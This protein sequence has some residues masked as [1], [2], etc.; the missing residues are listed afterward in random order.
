MKKIVVLVFTAILFASHFFLLSATEFDRNKEEKPCLSSFTMEEKLAF[1]SSYGIEVP[2]Y[3]EDYIVRLIDMVETDPGRQIVINNPVVYQT[4][5]Q[6]KQIVNEY[7]GIP[8]DHELQQS[9]RYTLVDSTVYGSWYSGL[10]NYNC[11]AYAIGDSTA[12]YWPG[13]FSVVPNEY[14]LN[15]SN[16]IYTFATY[17]RSD[18]KSSDFSKQCVKLTTVRPSSLS[19][20]QSCMAIRK[21][22][23]DFHFMKYDPSYWY[24]K[25]GGSSILKY[26]YQPTVGRTWTNEYS[27][28]GVAH[29][30]DTYYNSDIYY[31]VYRSNHPSTTYRW[32]GEHYHS[33]NKHYF[34]YGDQ[35][36]EC[37]EFMNLEWISQSCSGPPCQ[38]PGN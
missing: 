4:A 5:T 20:G 28:D 14:N 38:M 13:A 21:C 10:G 25:P 2:D 19:Q 15:Y 31:I 17:V 8:F 12:F 3:A 30:P 7:Y 33:G 1:L 29:S 23:Y 37:G 9:S 11:Y 16:S 32:T 27:I 36:D 26:N 18:L 6:V 22:T 24:H 34:R 35:C